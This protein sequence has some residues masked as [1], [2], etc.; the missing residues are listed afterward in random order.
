MNKNRIGK[1]SPDKME[2]LIGN[3][4]GKC[5]NDVIVGPGAGLDAAVLKLSDGR[6]MAIAEDPIFPAPGLPLETFGW[7]TV[8]IG[9]SDVAVT[10][11]KP[12]FMTYTLLLPPSFSEEDTRKII[13]SISKTAEELGI[14]I[15]GGHTGWYGAVTVPTVGGVSV[16]GFADSDKWISPGGARDG[17]SILMTK[18]PSIE[19]SALL[20]ILKQAKLKG[21]I[22]DENIK[23][24]IGRSNE[25]TV[26]KDALLAFETGEVNAMHDATEGGVIGG[27]WEM[28]RSSGIPVFADFDR[29]DIPDDIYS[30][31]K[32]LNFNPWEAISEGTL[33]AAVKPGKEKKVM[34][35]LKANGIESWI[36]GRFDS[37]IKKNTVRQ[38]KLDTELIC[39]EE[40]PFW[41][42]FFGE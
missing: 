25:I 28:Y 6:V 16:W 12:Q 42:L 34:E 21:R 3:S 23:N 37:S 20:A 22:S 24:L 19:A 7:F 38:R 36:L 11:I 14:T 4:F 27:L 8:H 1:L 10:G 32:E 35:L 15:V 29:V 31:S 18:G 2:N 9:A 41:K 39:P 5:S 40:D 26:V 30:I 33:L 17:D 13:K